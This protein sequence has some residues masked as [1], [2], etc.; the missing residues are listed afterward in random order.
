MIV[1]KILVTGSEG[2]LG[3]ELCRYFAHKAEI[4]ALNKE[5]LDITNINNVIDLCCF[6]KPDIIINAAAFTNVDGCESNRELSF[7]A[8]SI[9]P[10]NL[11]IACNRFDIGLV[12]I[13]TDFIFD[14]VK[15]EPY[16]ETDLPN[17]I[18]RY[19]ETKWF[20]EAFIKELCSR[21]FI[22]RTSWLYGHYGHNFVRTMLKLGEQKDEIS[23]VTDQIGTPTYTLD[24]CSAIDK[25]ISSDAYGTYHVSNSG[26]CSW[27]EFAE[28][29]FE[30]NN[31][32]NIK[33][34][35]ISSEELDRPARRPKYS[36]LRNYMLELQFDYH[37]PHWE[38]ALER[39]FASSQS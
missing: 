20:G 9:G 12:Q 39:F 7:K 38:D 10:R 8:N 17:P 36:V 14:G 34:R 32:N 31:K 27:H 1:L 30:L 22:V 4:T 16:L 21:F 35:A 13:S 28:K 3:R 18:N 33:V 26:Q 11:A 25:L 15:A 24:L 37:L 6:A 2:Q 23:V 19:G 29:I 5:T